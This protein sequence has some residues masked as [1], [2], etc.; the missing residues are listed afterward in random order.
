MRL[1]EMLLIVT[2][3]AGVIMLMFRERLRISKRITAGAFAAVGSAVLLQ[4]LAEGYRWMVVPAYFA[5]VILLLVMAYRWFRKP[6]A[7]LPR[8]WTGYAGCVGL[9]VLLAASTALSSLLPVVHLPVPEGEFKVGTLQ[10]AWIDSARPEPATLQPE[11]KREIPVQIWYPAALPLKGK[12]EMLFGGNRELTSPLLKEYARAMQLPDFALQ[13]WRYFRTNSYLDAPLL[14]SP[15]PYPVVIISHG[16]GT[17]KVF[18]VSQAENL[19]S[20]GYVVM[21]LEHPYS[22]AAALLSSGQIADFRTPLTSEDFITKAKELGEVWVA[23]IAFSIR[24]LRSFNSGEVSSL[25]KDK[26]D[27]EHIGI[28][29]HSFGGGAAYQA[30]RLLGDITAGI[31]MDGTLFGLDVQEPLTKPFMFMQAESTV[32]TGEGYAK[33]APP[34]I[35]EHLKQEAKAMLEAVTAGGIHLHVEG[36]EHFN[37]TD[38]QLYS[39]LFKYTGMTGSIE[40]EH[41]AALVN[42]YVLEFFNKHLKSMESPLIEGPSSSYPEVGF[43]FQP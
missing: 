17:G 20:H 16:L 10:L 42:R 1:F 36:A 13:Y 7:T 27:L 2:D 37:F 34:H 39:P 21:A 32:Q 14:P 22:S 41:G 25:F 18:H 15:K 5:S 23:D 30:T 31:N 40:G 26:L 6:A 28:M 11:D 12:P 29:G 4:L 35:R 8:R 19:A 3:L 33:D 24:Q 43:H 9:I 38:H